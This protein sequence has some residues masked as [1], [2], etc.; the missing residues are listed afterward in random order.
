MSNLISIWDL[1]ILENKKLSKKSAY[2]KE[3]C[4][5]LKKNNQFYIKNFE[6][7]IDFFELLLTCSEIAEENDKKRGN[8][9][10]IK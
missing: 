1:K 6:E 10:A 5:R 7:T 9:N 3:A 4:Q 2:L 8:A